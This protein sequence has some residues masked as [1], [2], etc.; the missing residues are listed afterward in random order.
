MAHDHVA[1]VELLSVALRAGAVSAV[2]AQLLVWAQ[3]KSPHIVTPADYITALDRY[4]CLAV[5]APD[6]Q[7]QDYL[8]TPAG[9]LQTF[10]GW[11]LSRFESN[12]Q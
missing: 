11:R 12:Q 7:C 4:R 8:R 3:R 5:C 10:L 9:F 1:E 2:D 6:V